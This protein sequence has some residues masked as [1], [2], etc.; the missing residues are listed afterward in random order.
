MFDAAHLTGHP[1]NFERTRGEA[2]VVSSRSGELP[3]ARHLRSRGTT[4]LSWT[5]E[6]A[7]GRRLG[8][9]TQAV[10]FGFLV[11]AAHGTELRGVNFGPHDTLKTAINEIGGRLKAT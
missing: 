9:I 8:T 4:P 5:L 6:T 7:N 2:W 3:L 11:H 1:A 10:G